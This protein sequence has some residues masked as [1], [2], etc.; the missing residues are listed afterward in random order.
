MLSDA[1]RVVIHRLWARK[2][3]Q[4]AREL[5]RTERHRNIEPVSAELVAC[6]GGWP[7]R[8]AAARDRWLERALHRRPRR[9]RAGNGGQA[10]LDRDR[11]RPP[12]RGQR[13]HSLAR[14]G[15]LRRTSSSETPPTSCPS[16]GEVA[17]VLIDCE[18]EDYNRFFDMLALAPG[19][20]VVADNIISHDL[21]SYTEHVRSRVGTES[22][23]LP[24]GK[25]LEVTRITPAYRRP[26]P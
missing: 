9:V 25:G 3:E 17:F 7:R 22:M 15:Q 24:I 5:P 4:D 19:S 10:D 26:A 23:T 2:L 11:T 13:D 14:A 12:G 8:E 6:P 20:V 21:S 16:V 18:K 1:E